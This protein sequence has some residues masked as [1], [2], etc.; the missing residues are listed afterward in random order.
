[1]FWVKKIGNEGK[2]K[3][4]ITVSKV[5]AGVSL[6]ALIA[7]SAVF[8]I[9]LQMEK[10]VLGKYEKGEVYAAAAAIPKGQLITEENYRQYFAIRELDTGCIPDTALK[11]PDQI[12]GLAAVFDVDP[13]VLLT[14]GMFES[15][16]DILEEMEEPVVAGFKAEDMYQVAGG[17]LRAGDRVHI[18]SITDEEE[19]LVWEKVYIQ[20]VFDASG[21]SIPNGDRLTAAQ[22][23]NI[24]LDKRDVEAFYRGLA[25]GSL[26]VV[27]ICR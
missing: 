27:K 12:Y 19:I 9:M 2:R 5:K 6:T 11:M 1:M 17:T 22:R 21:K 7:A 13:G 26:R 23:V 4:R 18:Y 14:T 10:S 16:E 15:L 8:V 3:Q 20:Q 24:Y 25:E